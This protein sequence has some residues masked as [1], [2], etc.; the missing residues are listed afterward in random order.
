M[1]EPAGSGGQTEL[2]RPVA[3]VELGDQQQPATHRRRQSTGHPDDAGAELIDTQ[4][5][6]GQ[7]VAD[8]RQRGPGER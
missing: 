6:V 2:D 8:R 3:G 4:L 1:A 7:L 5:P